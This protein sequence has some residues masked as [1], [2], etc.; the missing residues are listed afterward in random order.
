MNHPHDVG[1]GPGEG[2][3]FCG[4]PWRQ[5]LRLYCGSNCSAELRVCNAHAWAVQ[6]GDWALTVRCMDM[7]RTLQGAD[8]E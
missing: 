5:T 6:N 4:M 7:S 2:C 3:R 1:T 8:I